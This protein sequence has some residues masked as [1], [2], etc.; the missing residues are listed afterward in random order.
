MLAVM[1]TGLTQAN[2]QYALWQRLRAGRI[3]AASESRSWEPFQVPGDTAGNVIPAS[4]WATLDKQPPDL[5]WLTS[6]FMF[7]FYTGGRSYTARCMGVRVRQDGIRELVTPMVRIAPKAA[8]QSTT[9][10]KAE[11]PVEQPKNKGGR[12]PKPFWDDLWAD[13]ARACYVGEIKHTDTQSSV[14]QRMMDWAQAHGEEISVPTARNA[15]RRLM[16]ALRLEDKN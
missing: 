6:D 10:T 9:P 11:T 15:A 4:Y 14:E 8:G 16:Q 13:I 2:A 3:V 7:G 1:G 5:F 12:P